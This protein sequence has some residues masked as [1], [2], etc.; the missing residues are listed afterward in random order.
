M[1]PVYNSTF[2]AELRKL[3]V[4][5]ISHATDSVIAGLMPESEYRRQTG[6]ISGLRTCLELCDEAN[7]NI[8]KR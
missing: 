2:E 6:M 1:M 3:I 4:E 8:A 5:C 7:S